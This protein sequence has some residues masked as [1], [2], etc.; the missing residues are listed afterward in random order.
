MNRQIALAYGIAGL[1][2]ATALVVVIGSTVGL[3]GGPAPAPTL[4]L[5]AQVAPTPAAPPAASSPEVPGPPVPFA[6]ASDPEVVYV[7]EPVRSRR[8]GDDD[9]DDDE[10]DHHGHRRGDDEDDDD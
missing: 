1:A 9:H 5:T 4:P 6:G 3:F 2:V 8:H 10:D 7:D